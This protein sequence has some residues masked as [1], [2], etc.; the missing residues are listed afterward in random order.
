M[1][2]IKKHLDKKLDDHYS[3]V[4]T[5]FVKVGIFECKARIT[6]PITDITNLISIFYIK[7]KPN[8]IKIKVSL[9]PIKPN[10]SYNP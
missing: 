7:A 6:K 10:T 3:M 8:I 2:T 9:T 5:I 4:F 1:E